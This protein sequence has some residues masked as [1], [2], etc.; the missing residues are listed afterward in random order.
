MNRRYY[1]SQAI[2]NL[3]GNPNAKFIMVDDNPHDMLWYDEDTK[4]PHPDEI[5]EEENKIFK[6]LG[7]KKPISLLGLL[8]SLWNDI[9][10]NKIPG[11]DGEFYSLFLDYKNQL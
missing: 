2:T 6:N 8:D 7:D 4:R 5:I 1:W 9:N 10:N 11:K 3:T